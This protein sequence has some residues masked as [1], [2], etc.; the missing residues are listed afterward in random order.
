MK[1]WSSMVAAFLPLVFTAISVPLRT[2]FTL[3]DL[4]YY[5]SAIIALVV[6]TVMG[7]VAF[8]MA[9]VNMFRFCKHIAKN[10]RVES[11]TRI[12]WIICTVLFILFTPPVYWLVHL[13]KEAPVK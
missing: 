12:I 10:P 9:I 7:V 1:K 2:S 11:E 3:S 13:R 8:V 5:D 4:L 6:S